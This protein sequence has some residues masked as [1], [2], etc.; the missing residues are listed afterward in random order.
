ML[1]NE[2][3]QGMGKNDQHRTILTFFLPRHSNEN[4]PM[5][6]AFTYTLVV[7]EW[8]GFQQRGR[9]ED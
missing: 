7:E 6:G 2:V 9:P 1:P 5:F 4:C 3:L 8:G